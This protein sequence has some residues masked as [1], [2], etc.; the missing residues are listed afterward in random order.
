MTNL[1]K[2]TKI[3]CEN[4]EVKKQLTKF[5]AFLEKQWLRSIKNI[6]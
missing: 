4:K 3:L 1:E 2:L 5:N 6:N